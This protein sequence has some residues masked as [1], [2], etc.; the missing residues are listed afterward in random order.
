[1]TIIHTIW[2]DT[3][4]FSLKPKTFMEFFLTDLNSRMNIRNSIYVHKY[5]CMYVCMDGWIYVYIY[6]G[7]CVCMHICLYA[8]IYVCMHVCM[9]NY[10][11]TLSL[12]VECNSKSIFKGNL[13]RF[14]FR[15]F[16]HTKVKEPSLSYYLPIVEERIV[17]F[18]PFLVVWVLCKMQTALN[19]IWTQ[20][21]VSIFYDDNRLHHEHLGIACTF[22]GLWSFPPWTDREIFC[23]SRNSY[24]PIFCKSVES[25][26]T[27][28]SS[29]P[30]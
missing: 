17:G 15:V 23:F 21:T 8:F 24:S 9:Y 10:L 26:F 27:A 6:L 19:R 13:N 3:I 4:K 18:L 11:L 1:M 5:I 14:E 25:L 30:T 2:E 20:V 7:I 28:N 29:H 22:H 12:R 16:F